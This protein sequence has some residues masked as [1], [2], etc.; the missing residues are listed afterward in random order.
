METAI[1]L[2]QTYSWVTQEATVV[3]WIDRI[4][5]ESIEA[6]AYQNQGRFDQLYQSKYSG[7]SGIWGSFQR[8]QRPF[9]KLVATELKTDED[10]DEVLKAIEDGVLWRF[11]A[12]K[13]FA[14]GDVVEEVATDEE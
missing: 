4:L 2:C 12:T 5:Q 9:R 7:G 10:M 14:F 3:R 8:C 13:R 6:S 11:R 1:F